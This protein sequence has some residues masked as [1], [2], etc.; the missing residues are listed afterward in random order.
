MDA[1]QLNFFNYSA[2]DWDKNET[3][4]T[5][6]KINEL[7]DRLHVKEGS[8]ILDLGTGTGI[9][10][11]YLAKRIGRQGSILA[12]DL[13]TGMLEMAKKKYSELQPTP[14]FRLADFEKDDIEG[15]FDLIMLYCVY[16]HLSD[17]VATLKKLI[18][19]NLAEQGR[20]VIAF[21]ANEKVINN[22]HRE[23]KVESDLLPPASILAANLRAQGIPAT[24]FPDAPDSYTVVVG[25]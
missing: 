10:I 2:K 22:I 17:P 3:M 11:P 21:P 12:I 25:E 8:R 19:R 1:E 16:P 13:S 7:L 5:P 9:L 18:S 14:V 24:G 20:L 15:K 23:K 6:F 4:S